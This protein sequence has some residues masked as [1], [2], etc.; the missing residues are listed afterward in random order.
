MFA[1]HR[2]SRVIAIMLSPVLRRQGRRMKTAIPWLPP[3]KLPWRGSV[4]G[5]D[6]F[7]LLVLGD[8]TAAGVGV[9]DPDHGLGSNL[10]RVLNDRTGRG[11]EWLA[12]GEAGA[13]SKDLREK[14]LPKAV[15]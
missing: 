6:P 1:L 3:A 8:S 12:L 10:A 15:E 5:P 9:K 14:F 2:L 4:E 13:T 11:V 7:R